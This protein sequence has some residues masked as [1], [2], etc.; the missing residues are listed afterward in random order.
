[1]SNE[2]SEIS[3]KDNDI[4]ICLKFNLIRNCLPRGENSSLMIKKDDKEIIKRY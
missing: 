2:T 4:L 3:N 1:M